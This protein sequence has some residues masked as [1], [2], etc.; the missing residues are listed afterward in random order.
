MIT[1]DRKIRYP[2]VEKRAWIQHEVWGFVLTGRKSQTTADSLA[3]LEQH[4]SA[5]EALVD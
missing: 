4:R 2:P 5:I 1:R 3:I